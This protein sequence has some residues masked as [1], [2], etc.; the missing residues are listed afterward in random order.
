[1][2]VPR[3][4]PTPKNESGEP[5]CVV[6]NAKAG[7]RITIPVREIVSDRYT[8]KVLEGGVLVYTPVMKQ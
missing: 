7:Y 1:M 6:G 8:C 3:R 4:I 5:Y 2:I